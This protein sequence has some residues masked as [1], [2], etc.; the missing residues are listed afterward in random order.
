ML[1]KD[2]ASHPTPVDVL[3]PASHCRLAPPAR[4]MMRKDDARLVI[5]RHGIVFPHHFGAKKDEK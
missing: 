3:R 2:D 1:T 4:G 5:S